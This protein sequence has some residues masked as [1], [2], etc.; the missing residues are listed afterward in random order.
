MAAIC[1]RTRC[2]ICVEV[3]TVSCPLGGLVLRTTPRVSSRR[4][5]ALVYDALLDDLVG[6]LNALHVAALKLPAIATLSLWP[7][8]RTGEPFSIGFLGID[9]WRESCVIDFD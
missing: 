8:Y 2:G 9:D 3:H 1:V 7:S 6:L 5:S 4:E